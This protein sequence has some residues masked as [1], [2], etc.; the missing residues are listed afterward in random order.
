MSNESYTPDASSASL[1]STQAAFNE[2][3]ATKQAISGIDTSLLSP[4]TPLEYTGLNIPRSVL[5]EATPSRMYADG[6]ARLKCVTDVCNRGLVVDKPTNPT[7]VIKY[8]NSFINYCYEYQL[9]P[10]LGLFALWCGTTVPG[11]NTLLRQ[12]KNTPLGDALAKCK[13][14][15]RDFI[16]LAAIEGDL[17]KNI[18]LHMQ[19]GYFDVVE[20]VKLEHEITESPDELSVMEIDAIISSITEPVDTLHDVLVTPSE[21]QA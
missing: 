8:F 10:T 18:Y 5:N 13:E 21:S 4:D 2:L 16:E 19:K 9:A 15:L 14:A 12:W 11:Y 20:K 1:A 6:G 3:P 17:D 7:T